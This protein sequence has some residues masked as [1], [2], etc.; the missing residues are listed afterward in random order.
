MA[1]KLTLKQVREFTKRHGLKLEHESM[2]LLGSVVGKNVT[3]MR[4]NLKERIKHQHSEFFQNLVHPSMEKQ[5][6]MHLTRN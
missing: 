4:K 2:E 1:H 5:C 6:A 3:Q